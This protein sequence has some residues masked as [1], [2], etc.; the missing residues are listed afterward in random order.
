MTSVSIVFHLST[1]LNTNTQNYTK[2]TTSK[3]RT[4]EQARQDFVFRGLSISEWAKEHG[5]PVRTVYAVLDGH[6]KGERGQAHRA[7]VL[8]GIKD[9]V[10]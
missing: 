1:I 9:G 5:L 8:L 6:N 4:R 7:A 2:E 3:K 10:V